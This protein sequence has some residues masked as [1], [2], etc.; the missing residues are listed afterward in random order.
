[1]STWS[2][3]QIKAFLLDLERQQGLYVRMLAQTRE[4]LQRLEAT[5]DPLEVT[6]ML[7]EKQH[8][9]HELEGLEAELAPRKLEWPAVREALPASV[10]EFAEGRLEQLQAALRELIAAEDEAAQAVAERVSTGR[11]KLGNMSRKSLAGR[12]YATGAKAQ[13]RF[14]DGTT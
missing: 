6:R 4:Q 9:M 5:E 8:L 3:E 10:R 11:Q 14:V 7:A 12:A 1:M 2:G 13:P